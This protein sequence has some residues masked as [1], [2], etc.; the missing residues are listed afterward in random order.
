MVMPP[1]TSFGA[2]ECEGQ[3]RAQPLPDLCVRISRDEADIQAFQRLRYQVFYQEGGAQALDPAKGDLDCDE[4]DGVCDHLLVFDRV[5]QD[6]VGGYRLTRQEAADQVGGFMARHEF[7]I[8]ALY[9]H[10]GR[11]LELSRACVLAS[12]RR[13]GVMAALWQAVFNY[14]QR[15]KIDM[16]FGSVS[17]PGIDP[18]RWFSGLAWLRA[19]YMAPDTRQTPALPLGRFV[20]PVVPEEDLD[21]NKIFPLLPPL[22]KGYIRLGGL[23]SQEAF[24]DPIF[25]TIS[26]CLTLPAGDLASRYLRR[27]QR[28]GL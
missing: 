5:T 4:Y 28:L 16:L 17:F 10:G 1:I 19:K 12:Y 6:L 21:E 8:D 23:F 26:V 15:H 11:L 24:I 13:Q 7:Q 22:V 20:L 9:A 3:D 2:P 14:I 27:F 25:Q 18:Q